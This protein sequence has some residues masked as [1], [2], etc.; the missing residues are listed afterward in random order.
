MT[1]TAETAGTGVASAGQVAGAR[2]RR[3]RGIVGAVLAVAVLAV[4]LAALRPAAT[5]G[6]LDPEDATD[7]GSRALAEIVRQNGTAVDVRRSAAD[8]VAEAGASRLLVV[9]RDERLTADDVAALAASKAPL[10]LIEP[11]AAV[12]R[13]LAPE[14]EETTRAT[15]TAMPD[16]PL[17][18][19]AGRVDFGTASVYSA[20]S[21]ATVCY[22]Y[23]EF[24]RV[25]Q[26][27]TPRAVTVVGSGL[28]FTNDALT[29]EGNAA[30]AMNL[31]DAQGGV[32]W[33]LPRLPAE[34]QDV[35]GE[36][37][38]MDLVPPGVRLFFWQILIAVV[39]A[40]LWRAR[41]LGPVVVERLPVAV[42]SAEAVEGRAR[43][44]R[45]AHARDRAALALRS[46]ARERLVPLLGLPRSAAGELDR[47]AEVSALVAARSGIEEQT[48]RWALY[49]PDPADDRQLLQL[50]DLLDELER[51]VR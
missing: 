45:A 29:D 14:I 9:T 6:Y 32:V 24:A 27:T 51:R 1:A 49:G 11:S 40:A 50:T 16:C 10:L 15:G 48:A 28:P 39:L 7:Y 34:G 12:L 8:A 44:Y 2:F 31:L 5:S 38:F 25:V 21:H 42:R 46:A 35:V 20:P 22:R 47:A 36:E 17:A 33:L 4:L 37:S 43:L 23:E 26:V 30:F 18:S 19:A 3:W 41:R 13:E